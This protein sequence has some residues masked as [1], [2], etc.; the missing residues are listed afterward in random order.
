[1]YAG[2]ML[3]SG[4]DLQQGGFDQ[5]MLGRHYRSTITSSLSH[6]TYGSMIYL[7]VTA[8]EPNFSSYQ[9][10]VPAAVTARLVTTKSSALSMV[11]LNNKPEGAARMAKDR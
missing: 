4:S 10:F 3:G 2:M 5:Y 8:E 9:I 1:M 6:Q 11:Q 7:P